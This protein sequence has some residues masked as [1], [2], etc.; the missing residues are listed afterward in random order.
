MSKIHALQGDNAGC[1]QVVLHMAIPTGNN[2][3]A[4]SWKNAWIGAGL[5]VSSMISGASPGQITAVELA[6]IISGD[7]METMGVIPIAVVNQGVVAVDAFADALI[8]GFTATM[9]GKLA[10]YGWTH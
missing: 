7:V 9:K 6:S 8:A 4:V 5:N 2:P 1:Y 10:Y 3:V